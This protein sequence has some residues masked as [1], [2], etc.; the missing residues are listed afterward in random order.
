MERA[1][2]MKAKVKA[3]GQILN[4]TYDK[5]TRKWVSD[6]EDRKIGM[7]FYNKKDLEFIEDDIKQE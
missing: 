7:F 6:V 5:F 1:R 2:K 3:T 4:V